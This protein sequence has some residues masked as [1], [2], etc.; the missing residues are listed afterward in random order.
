M[1][2]FFQFEKDIDAEQTPIGTDRIL[3]FHAFGGSSWFNVSGYA[4]PNIYDEEPTIIEIKDAFVIPSG[5]YEISIN[6]DLKGFSDS[7]GSDRIYLKIGNS[8]EELNSVPKI[9]TV[10]NQESISLVFSF[11]STT[12]YAV[13]D[14]YKQQED[15]GKDYSIQI[16]LI[17]GGLYDREKKYAVLKGDLNGDGLVD[18]NDVV[19]MRLHLLGAELENESDSFRYDLNEDGK[20]DA[21]DLLSLQRYILGISK[22]YDIEF[23]DEVEH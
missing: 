3:K 19:L 8:Y 20:I 13:G 21:V 22:L 18:L 12:H 16:N 6:Q 4:Y 14:Y 23:R 5:E 2:N 9:I 10:E 1:S 15:F 17:T 7:D 11:Q